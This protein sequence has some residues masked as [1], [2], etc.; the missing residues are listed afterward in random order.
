[1]QRPYQGGAN[2]N[3]SG[4]SFNFIK[5]RFKRISC[6]ETFDIIQCEDKG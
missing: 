2:Q 4:S 3:G 6:A 1:M 5:V